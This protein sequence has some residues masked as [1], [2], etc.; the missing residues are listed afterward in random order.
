MTL[1][2]SALVLGLARSG[3]AAFAALER[4]GVPV[5]GAD[6]ELGNDDD[7]PLLDGAELLV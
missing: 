4:R 5:V 1:P 7:V 2:R 6:R 3:Q